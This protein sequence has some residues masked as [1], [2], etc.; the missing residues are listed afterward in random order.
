MP[1]DSLFEEVS[2]IFVCVFDDLLKG[3]NLPKGTVLI[4]DEIDSFLFDFKP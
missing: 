2:G 3:K 1:F 4:I